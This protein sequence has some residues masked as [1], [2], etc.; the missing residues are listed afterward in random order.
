MSGKKRTK[1]KET[2]NEQDDKRS[3][4]E[5]SVEKVGSSLSLAS[6]DVLPAASLSAIETTAGKWRSEVSC[7]D[8]SYY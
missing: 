6:T 2:K 4:T 3:N 5:G 7:K 8:E 1:A